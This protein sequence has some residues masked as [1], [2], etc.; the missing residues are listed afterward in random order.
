MLDRVSSKEVCRSHLDAVSSMCV[1]HALL[2]G[3]GLGSWL[4][5]YSLI[6]SLALAASK[7]MKGKEVMCFGSNMCLAIF[8]TIKR[9][10]N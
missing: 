8:A 6:C 2:L 7:A 5:S 1:G 10:S 3:L 9:V 4:Q